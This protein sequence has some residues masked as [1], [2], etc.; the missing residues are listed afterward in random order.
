M[1]EFK[2]C[3]FCEENHQ[4]VG[5]DGFEYGFLGETRDDFDEVREMIGADDW[6][7]VCDVHD[8]GCGA[9]CG[10]SNSREGAI[11]KWNTRAEHTCHLVDVDYDDGEI[12]GTTFGCSV[13]GYPHTIGDNY[14]PRCG[15][16]AVE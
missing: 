11:E 13:C 12:K 10:Y 14:C 6:A 5:V 4:V 2:P 8:G 16:K 1:E 3:P 15:A 7:V 9:T